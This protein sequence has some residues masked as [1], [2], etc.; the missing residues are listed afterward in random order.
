MPGGICQALNTVSM[1][2]KAKEELLNIIILSDTEA[3][4]ASMLTHSM[5]YFTFYFILILLSFQRAHM[6]CGKDANRF[7]L[8]RLIMVRRERPV[9][10]TLLCVMRPVTVCSEIQNSL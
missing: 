1:M 6:S 5:F 4:L 8:T 10:V 7:I 9:I 2:V 3:T